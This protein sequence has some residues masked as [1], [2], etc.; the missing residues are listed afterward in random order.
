MIGV[1]KLLVGLLPHILTCLAALKLKIFKTISP[2]NQSA[3]FYCSSFMQQ[4]NNNN[5]KKKQKNDLYWTVN[6][7]GLICY[8]SLLLPCNSLV[9]NLQYFF[10]HNWQLNQFL[11]IVSFPFLL[12]YLE[13]V[14]L[15]WKM[16]ISPSCWFNALKLLRIISLSCRVVI[17]ITEDLTNITKKKKTPSATL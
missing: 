8:I 2:D 6:H 13:E 14:L 4:K 16:P 17:N 11:F 7:F 15:H 9:L 10:H 3:N 1:T 12:N 5:N